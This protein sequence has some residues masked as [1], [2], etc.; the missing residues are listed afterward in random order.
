VQKHPKAKECVDALAAVA[1]WE[2]KEAAVAQEHYKHHP[3]QNA[4]HRSLL[5]ED[6][7][8]DY[9]QTTPRLTLADRQRG[10]TGVGA[11]PGF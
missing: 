5:A 8:A 1:E 6:A 7:S 3:T 2:E 10:L 9:F 4:Q 11:L